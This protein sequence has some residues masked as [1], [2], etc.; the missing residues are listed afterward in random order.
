MKRL[1]SLL[2]V[3]ALALVAAP[4]SAAPKLGDSLKGEAK[5]A[6]EDGTR[7]YKAGKF[8]E[9]R[10][11]FEAAY[12]ASGDKRLLFNVGVCEKS[13]GHNVAAVRA[14]EESLVERAS[15]PTDYIEKAQQ[16]LAAL[17][18]HVS[19]LTVETSAPGATIKVDGEEVTTQPVL[20]DEGE[21]VVMAQKKGYQSVTEKVTAQGGQPIRVALILKAAQIARVCI[22]AERADD[23]LA[24]DDRPRG[25]SPLEA[26]LEPGEHHVV[27]ARPGGPTK[28][29]TFVL[30]EGET[31]ELRVTLPEES[32][33][34]PWWFVVGGVIV[35]GA[36]T[37]AIIVATRPTKYE[38]SNVGL[39]DPGTVTAGYRGSFR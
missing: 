36:A 2:L 19:N 10:T 38:G 7:L 16:A 32:K 35:A 28:K 8:D 18:E 25:I 6:F 12:K 17:R 5:T 39:L 21:H 4:A 37:T 9:A 34:S 29:V 20:V 22:T 11:K 23:T 14:L 3:C 24:I 30:R 13:L 1:V 26:E 33:L 27:V 15:L 31:R